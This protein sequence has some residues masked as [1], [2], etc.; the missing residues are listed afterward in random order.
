MIHDAADLG[1]SFVKLHNAPLIEQNI[2]YDIW[3]SDEWRETFKAISDRGLPVL[4][5]V[6]QRLPSI[7]YLGGGRNT[8]WDTGWEHGTKFTNEDLLQV[9]LACCRQFPK[10]NFIG[11]HQLHI[12]WDRLCD[13]FT[14]YPNLYVDT[15]VGCSLK[16]HDDFYPHDKEYLREVFLRRSERIIYGTDSFWGTAGTS[17]RERGTLEHMRFITALDLTGGALN[18]ICHGNIE[19]LYG[20]APLK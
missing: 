20:I 15:T 19:R 4:W 9:F 12:G 8:Y 7:D 5:H 11:A 13:L 17:F 10:I 18:N 2:P 1:A 3:L 16:L 14:G 6:A